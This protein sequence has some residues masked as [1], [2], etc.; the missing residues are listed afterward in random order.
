MVLDFYRITYPTFN[1]KHSSHLVTRAE[2][3]SVMSALSLLSSSSMGP[4]RGSCWVRCSQRRICCR[5]C[6]IR[7]AS[8]S[9][10]VDRERRL[11]YHHNVE[12]KEKEK[13]MTMGS[14][15]QVYYAL[16]YLFFFSMSMYFIDMWIIMFYQREH[17]FWIKNIRQTFFISQKAHVWGRSNYLRKSQPYNILCQ[18]K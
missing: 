18:L 2:M 11:R 15:M 3:I 4:G 6:Q 12:I 14:S 16:I 13:K 5:F 1:P 10:L 7:S 17:L 9:H 8:F